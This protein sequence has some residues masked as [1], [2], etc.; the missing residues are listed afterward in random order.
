MTTYTNSLK[1]DFFSANLS[2][3]NNATRGEL[4]NDPKSARSYSLPV[5]IE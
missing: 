1:A 2:V 4:T 3:V 5:S